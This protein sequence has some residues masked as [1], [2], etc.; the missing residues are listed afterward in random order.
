MFHC[1]LNTFT[2]FS[3]KFE[4]V[5]FI[6]FY[7]NYK[8]IESKKAQTNRTTTTKKRKD[9]PE[10]KARSLI[11]ISLLIIPNHL[12][13]LWVTFLIFILLHQSH[14]VF[15]IRETAHLFILTG[16]LAGDQ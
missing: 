16:D 3:T 12:L 15:M 6:I 7:K 4:Q 10:W 9:V 14:T 2:T 13:L 5:F 1:A 8:E 11:S